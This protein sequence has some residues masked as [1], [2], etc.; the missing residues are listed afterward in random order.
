MRPKLAASTFVVTIAA[1]SASAAASTPGA[2]AA[3]FPKSTSAISIAAFVD[4]AATQGKSVRT[5]NARHHT[6]TLDGQS[7]SSAANFFSTGRADGFLAAGSSTQRSVTFSRHRDEQRSNN[8]ARSCHCAAWVLSSDLW[9]DCG[10][11]RYLLAC[12]Q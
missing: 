6:G 1:T 2:A 11:V 10:C 9:G 3:A 4:I 7:S 8:H 12:G 5:G